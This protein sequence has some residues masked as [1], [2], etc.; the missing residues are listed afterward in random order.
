MLLRWISIP[1]IALAWLGCASAVL[2]Q[3]CDSAGSNVEIKNCLAMAY[4]KADA[5]LNAIWPQVLASVDQA[6]YLTAE[7]RAAWKTELREAQR[8]WVQF[9]EH[10]CNGAVLYEWWGG[11]GAGG[12]ISSCLLAHTK[13]RTDDLKSRYLSER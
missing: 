7:Q 13:A 10:D 4:D 9:K 1:W 6:D 11:S 12:A 8:A 3:D 2:A 5:E